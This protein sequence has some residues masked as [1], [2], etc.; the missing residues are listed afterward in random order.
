MATS[1]NTKLYDQFVEASNDR[2]FNP[3]LLGSEIG[4]SGDREMKQSFLQVI[5]GYLQVVSQDYIYGTS[6]LYGTTGLSK[7]AYEMLQTYAKQ[8]GAVVDNNTINLDQYQ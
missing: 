6:H 5:L 4:I 1:K 7:L 3:K 8:T 2:R